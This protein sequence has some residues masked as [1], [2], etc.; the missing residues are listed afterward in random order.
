MQVS[1]IKSRL[2]SLSARTSRHVE[3][4]SLFLQRFW[5][6]SRTKEIAVRLKSSD[7]TWRAAIEVWNLR[8]RIVSA[9]RESLCACSH[10]IDHE[11][12]MKMRWGETQEWRDTLA[13]ELLAFHWNRDD[14]IE[15][16]YRRPLWA[17]IKE[18]SIGLIMAFRFAF[19]SCFH[20]S[21]ERDSTDL[22]LNICRP[23]W[24]LRV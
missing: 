14:R 12:V 1:S 3:M 22:K 11:Y 8:W 18:W 19:D 6:S 17:W 4:G 13:A 7:R 24:N 2:F 16:K 9:I 21:D 10:Q 15:K 5:L 20:R 23:F